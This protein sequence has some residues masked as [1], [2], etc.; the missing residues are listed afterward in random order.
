MF[1]DMGRATQFR[2]TSVRVVLETDTP[3]EIPK[4]FLKPSKSFEITRENMVSRPVDFDP[5]P[6][7]LNPHQLEIV[8]GKDE[9]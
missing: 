2:P 3:I 5:D 6:V 8:P 4:S 9:G 7:K 1:D